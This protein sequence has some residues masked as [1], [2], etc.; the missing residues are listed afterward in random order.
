MSRRLQLGSKSPVIVDFAVEHQ[1]DGL[2]FVMDGLMSRGQIDDAQPSHP[3]ADARL[4]MQTL[5][6]RTPMPD[7][8][9]HAV[10][11]VEVRLSA[12]AV[13]TVRLDVGETGYSTHGVVV[14]C[15]CSA[16]VI[17]PAGSP[18]QSPPENGVMHGSR[19]QES[20]RAYHE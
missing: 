1:P 11:Q 6:V 8:L 19:Q 13:W 18:A 10:H 17:P 2:V 4:H 5:I 7:D 14:F 15:F 12:A 20:Q 16:L 9:A 3:E